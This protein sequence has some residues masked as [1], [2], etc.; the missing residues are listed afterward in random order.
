MHVYLFE[1]LYRVVPKGTDNLIITR[2]DLS[3]GKDYI[4]IKAVNSLA[5]GSILNTISRKPS[6]NTVLIIIKLCYVGHHIIAFKNLS[7]GSLCVCPVN[8]PS[9]F[10]LK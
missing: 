5:R 6:G 9:H 8:S 10:C 7:L 2:N 3:S 1:V 4:H